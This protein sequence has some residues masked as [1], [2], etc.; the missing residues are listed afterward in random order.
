MSVGRLGVG[1]F[2]PARDLNSSKWHLE[3]IVHLASIVKPKKYLE[4]GIFQAGLINR[5]SP[6]I[7]EITAVD[8]DPQAKKYIRDV[9]RVKFLNLDSKEFWKS[10]GDSEFDMIFIDGNH[11]RESVLSDFWGALKVVKDQGLILLHDT[12]PRDFEATNPARCDNGYLAIEEVRLKHGLFEMMTI[13]VHP[14]LTIVRKCS[15]Q[16]PWA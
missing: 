10:Y 16:V 11:S 6:L 7:P 8:I 9:K 4:V 12:Y 5:L 1:T 3:F 14:G 13:P 2:L 15:Q